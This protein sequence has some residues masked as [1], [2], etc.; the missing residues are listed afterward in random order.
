MSRMDMGMVIRMVDLK[1]HQKVQLTEI[2]S[3]A[4]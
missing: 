4:V 2:R 1:E 3:E